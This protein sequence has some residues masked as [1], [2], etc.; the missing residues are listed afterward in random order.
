MFI[1]KPIPSSASSVVYLDRFYV[2]RFMGV[3][4][5]KVLKTFFSFG[6]LDY[7]FYDNISHRKYFIHTTFYYK[8]YHDKT[9][10]RFLWYFEIIAVY[11]NQKSKFCI[12][13]NKSIRKISGLK[14]LVGLILFRS[15]EIWKKCFKYLIHQ[16]FSF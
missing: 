14:M 15:I 4:E 2:R 16:I 13:K 9:I 7:S 8:N 12:L 3:S 10:T 11:Q 1:S 6:Q 5:L